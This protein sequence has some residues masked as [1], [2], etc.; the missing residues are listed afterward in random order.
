[1]ILTMLLFLGGA[2]LA[3]LALALIVGIVVGTISTIVVA[4]PVAVLLEQ[5]WPGMPPRLAESNQPTG[6]ARR[7][8]RSRADGGRTRN[9]S[10]A[11]V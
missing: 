4:G 8:D 3:D 11:V 7:R 5:R 10:G 9:A 2:T 6:K 1:V